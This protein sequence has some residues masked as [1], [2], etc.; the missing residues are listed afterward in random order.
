MF[1]FL[2]VQLFVRQGSREEE[3]DESKIEKD[4]KVWGRNTNAKT[5]EIQVPSAL[6]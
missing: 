1:C 5:V 6:V 3:I 4:A 2:F